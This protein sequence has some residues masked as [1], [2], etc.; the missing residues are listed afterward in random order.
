MTLRWPAIVAIAVA[1]S[2]AASGSFAEQY[3][4]RPIRLVVP[5]PPGGTADIMA[6]TIQELMSDALGQPVVVDSK[7]GAAGII[8]TR[9]VAGAAPDGYTLLFTNTGP[10]AVAPFL[11]PDAGYDPVADFVAVS[12]VART[13]LLLVVHPSLGAEDLPSLI[14]LAREK[15]DTINYS[16]A[17]PG[18]FGHLSTELLAVTAGMKLVHIPYKGQAPATTAVLSGE[19]QMALTS[20]SGMMNEYIRQGK[21]RLLGVSTVQPSALAPG[22]TPIGTVVPNFAAAFWFGVIAPART[23]PEII[24][25]LNAAIVNA[26]A[27]PA[28]RQKFLD[29][30][31]IA[32]A[33]TPEEF[34]ALIGAEA[35]RWRDV[36]N[37]TGIRMN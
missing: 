16:S 5:Y 24:A 28:I 11:Q 19:V 23:R 14:R 36:I 20:P 12:L 37:K 15:P 32:E 7:P 4:T 1:L 10:S 9:D 21:L 18:S 31:A 29:Y 13:P 26:L 8:A 3:P 30:G 2:A 6:R 35:V 22:A 25:K 33:S 17:G 27:M 34:T